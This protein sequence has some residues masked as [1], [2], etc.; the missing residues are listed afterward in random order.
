MVNPYIESI[1][2]RLEAKYAVDRLGMSQSQWIEQNTR[3]KKKPFSLKGYEF[4]RDIIDD[5]HPNLDVRKCSQVGMALALDTPVPTPSG[6]TTMGHVRVGD[7]VFDQGGKVC[8][9][10]YTSPIYT[11][12]DC[13]RLVFDDGETLIAD[14][15]HRWAVQSERSF[16]LTGAHSGLGRPPAS[17]QMFKDGVLTTEQILKFYKKGAR[18]RFAVLNSDPLECP[19]VDLPVDPYFLGLWLGD[20]N[21][22]A[23]CLTSHRADLPF[24]EAELGR[25]G[26]ICI[27]SSSKGDTVQV[28]VHLPGQKAPGRGVPNSVSSRLTSIGLMKG[29]KFV[30]SQYL[31][32]SAE[33]RLDL[34]RGLL[35]TDGSIT[36][37]GRVSFHNT[38]QELVSAAE[39]L[40]HSLGFKTRTRWRMPEPSV[41]KNGSTITPKKWIAEVSFVAYADCAVFLLP[42]KRERLGAR[43]GG[44]PTEALRR[45]I[46]GVEAVPTTP[47]RCISVGSPQHLF[48]AGT[49]MIPTHNTEVQIRKALAFLMRNNGTKAI[50]T[51]PNEKM[52]KK[53]AKT[54]IQP[55]VSTNPVFNPE[56]SSGWARSMDLMQFDESYLLVTGSTEGDA[57]STDAD[58]VF[59]DEVDLTDQQM[60]A[61]FRSRMQNSKFRINQRFSTPTHVGFAIDKGFQASDQK[62]YLCRCERCGYADN[63]PQF[64]RDYIN[65]PGLPDHVDDLSKIDTKMLDRL[66]LSEA[67]VMC[68]RCRAPLNLDDYV[69]RQWVARFDSRS[70]VARGYNISP[71]VTSRLDIA[72]IITELLSY[73]QR[74]YLRG[75]YNTVLGLPF[76]D[77]HARLSET[78]IRANLNGTD[79]I[80][81]TK[82][83]PCFVG[84]DVGL[85][86]HVIVGKPVVGGNVMPVRFE[87]V[88]AD[89]IVQWVDDFC[90]GHNV[91]AGGMDRYPYTPTANAVFEVSKGKIFPVE[92]RGE[93]EINGVK[94]EYETIT[95]FQAN[96]T[97][98]IDEV[99]KRVRRHTLPMAGYEHLE[100]IVIEHL[101]DMVRDEQPEKQATWIKINGNDHFF[102]ALAFLIFASKIDDFILLKSDSEQR[103]MMEILGIDTKATND[104][105]SGMSQRSR[106]Q[107]STAQRIHGRGF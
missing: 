89:E 79:P 26:M 49:G 2:G 37:G 8:T 71:F 78:D 22:H 20:G 38:C 65:L 57:T 56:G 63:I 14:S 30:P 41:M 94:N 76:T 18:N 24:Y 6:W 28:M 88:P 10:E 59:S 19:E 83:E 13:Y 39:E 90:Q 77:G 53:N 45:R 44:R 87:I 64:N 95:H 96:R 50:F 84:I 16:D 46:V 67:F 98:I 105:L 33:Q 7:Q 31:R 11:N 1:T 29:R 34:L 106:D 60:L 72:Y 82:D 104:G 68:K 48:L 54:R 97:Q 25:R 85:L 69:T 99:V 43:L 42:R 80:E 35:D 75:W 12:H 81:L 86:C 23:C 4:Q 27:P 52:F 70:Q 73:K 21:S 9:V 5:M 91:I 51:F 3:L 100:H 58:A 47:V 102:H 17:I 15:G 55:M 93:K 107:F 92:Y 101:R 36:R 66:Q 40:A 74:D 32:G 103:T 61:L 62:E